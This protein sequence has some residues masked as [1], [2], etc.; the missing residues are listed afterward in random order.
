MKTIFISII[1]VFFTSI[2]STQATSQTPLQLVD[3]VVLCNGDS[4]QLGAPPCGFDFFDDFDPDIDSLL[5]SEI[6]GM[7][8]NNCGAVS[9]PNAMHF[10][11][12]VVRQVT[13]IAL[14]CRWGG[15]ISFQ[16]K[17]AATNQAGCETADLGDDVV[18]EFSNNKF[19][20]ITINQYAAGSFP[21]FTQVTEPIPLFA[22]QTSYFRWRQVM[23]SGADLD[24]WAID[25]VRMDIGCCDTNCP[26]Y[27]FQWSPPVGISNTSVSNPFFSPLVSTQYYV[28]VTSTFGDTIMDSVYIE[29][30]NNCC[31]IPTNLSSTST[32]T[33]ATLSWDSVKGSTAY[34][35]QFDTGSMITSSPLLNAFTDS[36]FVY[37]DSLDTL[38]NYSWRVRAICGSDTSLW[39]TVDSILTPSPTPCAPPKNLNA[40][41]IADSSATLSWDSSTTSIAYTVQVAKNILDSLNSIFITPTSSTT[42]V[43]NLLPNTLY[44]WR[45][46]TM[47]TYKNQL[48]S[49]Y[50]EPD[51]FSTLASGLA[52]LN[53][54]TIDIYPNPSNGAFTI[55]MPETGYDIA[56]FNQEGKSIY[57]KQKCK[58]RELISIPYLSGGVY[59]VE[60]THHGST[61]IGKVVLFR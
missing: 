24:N 51:T 40:A 25:D 52:S 54:R 5:W 39:S 12:A 44:I 23:F 11:G 8:N 43:A 1:I 6:H 56:I 48:T 9:L 41:K 4:I 30:E 15:S 7:A 31:K 13:T 49:Q 47:C 29:V 3:S 37:I 32:P 26:P 61:F 27:Q 33:T 18:L 36:L 46:K 42:V 20:W 14:D 59:I 28:T 16:I 35:I 2:F 38:S 17:I 34:Q 60:A 55:D 50:S 45:V 21:V 53:N 57:K 22:S 58:T 10:N 19:S